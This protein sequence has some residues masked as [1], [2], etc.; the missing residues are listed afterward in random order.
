[1]AAPAQTNAPRFRNLAPVKAVLVLHGESKDSLIVREVT[2]L[3]R[4]DNL[5]L[6][7]GTQ[8]GA[9]SYR[10]EKS[11]IVRCEFDF[12]YDNMAVANALRDNDW[13]AAVRALSPIVR[14]S[15]PYLDIPDNNGLELAMDLGMYMVSSAD[16][17][18]RAAP[19]AAARE[20]AL[21][22]YAAAYEV[23]RCAA[24]ADWSPVG[25]VALLKGCLAR[26]A[27]GQTDKAQSELSELSPPDPDDPAYGHYW[28]V[29]GEIL[30]RSGSPLGALNAAVKS[31]AFANKD[32]ETFPLALLLSADCYAALGQYHRARDVYYEVAV[33]F[34]GT[35]W[36]ED[37]LA[38]LKG[39]MAD[40][41]TFEKEEE[42]IENVFFNMT[43]DMNK[44]SDELLKA[45]AKP[46]A[47]N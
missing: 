46:K 42:L 15:F 47:K 13:A 11:Q 16:R 36:A 9:G 40:K 37:A 19:D 43:E 10:I 5:L 41:K 32:I 4:A 45:R 2:L 20:R 39:I 31:V 6:A 22:Q 23:F 8:S 33:L 27:Q 29:T 7:Q 18:L 30:R 21:K 38:R 14:P 25:R 44:L 3:G 1:L 26:L 17:E 12:A 34:G 28:L 35:D 24:T